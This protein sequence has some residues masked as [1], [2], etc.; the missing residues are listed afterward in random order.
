LQFATNL[1][2]E[3]IAKFYKDKKWNMSDDTFLV[4]ADVYDGAYKSSLSNMIDNI[5]KIVV[6]SDDLKIKLFL[7]YHLY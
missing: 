2:K 7:L 4:I 6:L 1:N 3:A 5:L